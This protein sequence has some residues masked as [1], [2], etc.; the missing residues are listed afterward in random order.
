MD[1]E[2]VI[3]PNNW[4]LVIARLIVEFPNE[5]F[6]IEKQL[7]KS[8]ISVKNLKKIIYKRPKALP[9]S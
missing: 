8:Q 6:N 2:A 3:N 1:T 9:F 5:S 4:S 7:E